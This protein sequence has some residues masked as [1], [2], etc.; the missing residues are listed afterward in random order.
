MRCTLGGLATVKTVCGKWKPSSDAP[1]RARHRRTTFGRQDA[2]LSA[3]QQ[4]RTRMLLIQQH[5]LAPVTDHAH[6][7]A[8]LSSR[9]ALSSFTLSSARSHA[10]LITASPVL[11]TTPPSP[12]SRTNAATPRSSSATVTVVGNSGVSKEVGSGRRC[13]LRQSASA[14]CERCSSQRQ[15]RTRENTD[16]WKMPKLQDNGVRPSWS[17]KVSVREQMV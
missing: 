2:G 12:S 6:A 10:S 16:D 3:M 7:C 4:N 9:I 11:P 17:G 14:R 8:V 5:A 13:D 1:S 15:L